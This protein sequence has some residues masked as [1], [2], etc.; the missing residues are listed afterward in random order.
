[1][2]RPSSGFSLVELLVTISILATLGTLTFTGVRS[3]RQKARTVVEINA[4][5]NLITGYLGHAAEANGRV[6]PGYQADPSA[7]NLDGKPVDFPM[8][9]RYPWR[10]ARSVPAVR[11]VMVFN[12]NEKMLEGDNADYRVSAHP[13]LG[14]NA[15]LVGG[16]FGSGS[17][18]A[19]TPRIEEAYGKF[20]LSHLVESDNPSELVVFTSARADEHQAGYFEVR[21]PNLT[22]PV[23]SANAF[24]TGSA[25]SAHGFLDFRW[26]GKAV[27][28]MLGG[29][30]E[31]LDETQL[32]DMRRWSLQAARTGER[33]FT[34]RKAE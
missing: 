16:H 14:L 30:V 27:A 17:P 25:A 21:P 5:R 3:A 7:A 26:G 20:Y 23:W 4:A 34:I 28:A 24:S 19:P 8:N 6:M 31:L 2:K 12:G 9:A 33:N 13:N 11:G 1:M 10:L 32:R 18:L 15:T 29:N 22:A